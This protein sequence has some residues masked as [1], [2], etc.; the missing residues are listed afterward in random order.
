[1]KTD[2]S[3]LYRRFMRRLEAARQ[4]SGLLLILVLVLLAAG[5]G[6]RSAAGSWAGLSADGAGIVMANLD[7]VTQ[8]NDSGVERWK[9]P[10]PGERS[11]TQF[12]GTPALTEDV[13][14]VG[15]FDKKVYALNRANGQTVWV[16]EDA[17]AQIIGGLTVAQGHIVVGIGD[18]GVMA[19]NQR[20]GVQEWYFHTDQGVWST[21]LVVGDVVYIGSLDKN[22]YAL[23]LTT[24]EEIWR[25]DLEGAV[26]GMPVY[27]NNVLYVGSFAHKVFA[28][29]AATGEILNSFETDGWVWGSPAISEDNILYA[30]D[31]TGRVYARDASTFAPLWE[32][33]VALRAIRAA[34]L[35]VG[36]MVIVVSRDQH[37]YALDRTNGSPIWSQTTGGDVLSNPILFNSELVVVSTLAS[38]RLLVAYDLEG[39]EQWH[40]PPV[41][42]E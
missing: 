10:P 33:K 21:P 25:R 7:R 26:A 41:A 20:S 37:I 6:P 2:T 17:T 38:D 18:H 12:Y 24:G 39:Q 32:A 36:R 23:N 13:V 8:L 42:S 14:Y 28:I 9:F 35:V 34:P 1:L 15:G 31:L 16:N 5:C 30:A 3:P 11:Q 19:L 22:L 27:W 40:Y 4:H 29:D